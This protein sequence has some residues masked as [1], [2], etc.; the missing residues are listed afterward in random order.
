[1]MRVLL[2]ASK[3]LATST[4]LASSDSTFIQCNNNQ[5]GEKENVSHVRANEANK[6]GMTAVTNSDSIFSYLHCTH[7]P[8]TYM[9]KLP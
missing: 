3:T 5:H 9:L 4:L 6:K 2:A 1:M 8:S 7:I